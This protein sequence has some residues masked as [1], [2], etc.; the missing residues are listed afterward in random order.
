[1]RPTRT[2]IISRSSTNT[3]ATASRWARKRSRAS[4]RWLAWP[5]RSSSTSSVSGEADARVHVAIC[6]VRSKVG[7]HDERRGNGEDSHQHR[8]IRPRGGV[9][10]EA[11]HPGP[12]EDLLGDQGSD[13]QF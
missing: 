12:A 5:G 1:M 2:T 6:E 9:P 11:T 3:L 8:V 13:E 10:E 4:R 7:E